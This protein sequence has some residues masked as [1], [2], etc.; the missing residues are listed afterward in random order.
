MEGRELRRLRL[1]HGLTVSQ[2]AIMVNVSADDV[3]QW[4]APTGAAHAAPMS[5]T[6]RRQII[7]QLAL[8]RDREELVR[9]LIPPRVVPTGFRPG[10]LLP[11]ELRVR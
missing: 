3:Y 2:L 7:R 4:E 9:S 6:M 5:S 8:Y 10:H 1:A 11:A